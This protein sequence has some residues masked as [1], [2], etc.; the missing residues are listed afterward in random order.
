MTVWMKE[1]WQNFWTPWISEDIDPWSSNRRSV[2]LGFRIRS[3][4][5]RCRMKP[6]RKNW[7]QI[8]PPRNLKTEFREIWKPNSEK[9]KIKFREIWK[10]NSE[11]FENRIRTKRPDMDPGKNCSGLRLGP[12]AWAVCWG[13]SLNSGYYPMVN[14]LKL[15][16]CPSIIKG[17]NVFNESHLKRLC[18]SLLIELLNR[19]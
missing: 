10:P 11:K 8:Q 19:K 16:Y 7:I 4:I 18:I 12:P 3:D 15:T 2:I 5:D 9:L 13:K 1:K 17:H 6:L 14:I